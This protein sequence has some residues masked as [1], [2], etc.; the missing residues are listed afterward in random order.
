MD[1]VKNVSDKYNNVFTVYNDID[2]VILHVMI[3][4][5]HDIIICGY[6]SQL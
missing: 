5:K 6:L 4:N 1:Q 2:I 3:Y